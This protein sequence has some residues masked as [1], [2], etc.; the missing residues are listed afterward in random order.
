MLVGC[1][2]SDS[3]IVFVTDEAH[4]RCDVCGQTFAVTSLMSADVRPT[5]CPE[6]VA[7]T[8]TTTSSTRRAPVGDSFSIHSLVGD[9]AVQSPSAAAAA[10]RQPPP[11][12]AKHANS[13]SASSSP[14]L[15][16]AAAAHAQYYA[17][18]ASGLLPALNYGGRS[19]RVAAMPL[20]WA[21]STSLA[22][23]H[24]YGV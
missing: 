18:A 15:V 19:S 20:D 3:P 14:F 21:S 11:N 12:R 6:C 10:S 22:A 4:E 17:L 1:C 5:R 7:Q 8:A 13:S 9:T 16:Q 24:R 23:K 2:D